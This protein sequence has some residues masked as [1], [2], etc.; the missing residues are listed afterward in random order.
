MDQSKILTNLNIDALN[1]MQ[2]ETATA[3][4]K[5][6]NLVLI[7]PTG[8]GKTLAFLLPI[9]KLLN[10]NRIDV[11]NFFVITFFLNDN[12]KVRQLGSDK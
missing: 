3:F 4:E 8:S 10:S 2:F 6:N 5:T 11:K 9:L 7:S 1:Q 12:A